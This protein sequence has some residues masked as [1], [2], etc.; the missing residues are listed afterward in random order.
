MVVSGDHDGGS[1]DSN[2][3]FSAESTMDF[4]ARISA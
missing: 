2:E 3:V 1:L 4:P